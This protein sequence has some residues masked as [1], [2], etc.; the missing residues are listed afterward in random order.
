MRVKHLFS[1]AKIT[2]VQVAACQIGFLDSMKLAR[3][4][5]Q[6]AMFQATNNWDTT[7]LI[8]VDLLFLIYSCLLV[9]EFV[10]VSAKFIFVNSFSSGGQ[11]ECENYF[12]CTDTELT[13]S[14]CGGGGCSGVCKNAHFNQILYSRWTISINWSIVLCFLQCINFNFIFLFSAFGFDQLTLLNQL[15][16]IYVNAFEF[17]KCTFVWILLW[18]LETGKSIQP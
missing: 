14:N 17:A 1:I 11:S 5:F 7:L 15:E 8:A 10:A 3:N 16:N 6:Q 18:T 13:G 2:C 9:L 4:L 12:T